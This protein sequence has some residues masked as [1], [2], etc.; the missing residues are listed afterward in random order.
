MYRR[1]GIIGGTG[2]MGSWLAALFK[3]QGLE[4]ICCG[5]STPLKPRDI[6]GMSDVVVLSVPIRE[7]TDLIDQV[8]PLIPKEA[9]FMD[10]TS[11]KAE[12]MAGMLRQSRSEVV[13]LHPLFGPRAP[14]E[15]T[16]LKVAVCRGRGKDGLNWIISVLEAAGLK[17]LLVDPLVHDHLMGIIQ[18]V[19]HFAMIGL[20]LFIMRSNCPLDDLME[21]ATPSFS[22]TIERIQAMLAQPSELFGPLMMDNLFS[23]N[24]ILSYRESL[25]NLQNIIRNK[26]MDSFNDLFVSL[27]RYFETEGMHYETSMGEGGSLG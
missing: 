2:K 24:F 20:G 1:V 19:Q 23:S 25:E 21:Y 8:G 18:G 13:G 14:G 15:R 10:L 6:A 16:G 7:T 4:V 5:K 27:R 3:S 17:P 12:A 26:D 22:Q 9:L 11:I